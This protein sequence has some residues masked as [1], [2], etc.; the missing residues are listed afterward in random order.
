MQRE[1]LSKN[2]W[3]AGAVRIPMKRVNNINLGEAR[4]TGRP[5]S[6]SQE[7]LILD[8][9]R[10]RKC[11]GTSPP[12]GPISP[13]PPVPPAERQIIEETTSGICHNTPDAYSTLHRK[14]LLDRIMTPALLPPTVWLVTRESC[15][16]VR[17]SLSSKIT[18][19]T[20]EN[21][22]L[23]M[24]VMGREI[25]RADDWRINYINVIK[26]RSRRE[27]QQSIKRNAHSDTTASRR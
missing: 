1:L 22:A 6:V 13:R 25:A 7:P 12:L 27:R 16:F 11:V 18:Y 9:L 23:F 20:Q 10:R 8:L 17:A 24:I 21:D 26:N 19:K 5:D 3:S 14:G 4:R 15:F 2:K